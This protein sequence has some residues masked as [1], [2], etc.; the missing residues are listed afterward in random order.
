MAKRNDGF[1]L[2]KNKDVPKTKKGNLHYDPLDSIFDD[3]RNCH[4]DEKQALFL[5]RIIPR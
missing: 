4:T 5:S 1:D 3:C 2:L